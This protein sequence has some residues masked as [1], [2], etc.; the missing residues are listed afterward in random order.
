M[1]SAQPI[2]FRDYVHDAV[3]MTLRD[4]DLGNSKGGLNWICDR[5]RKGVRQNAAEL[6]PIDFLEEYLWCV[7]SIRK[8]YPTHVKYF[9]TQKELFLNCDACQ[10]TR[11][12]E[13]IRAA[14][15]RPEGRCDLSPRMFNAVLWTAGEIA[16]GWNGF[17]ENYLPLPADPE[18]ETQEAWQ[19]AY[20]AL[21]SL[22]MVGPALAWYLIRNLYGAP[23]FKPDVHIN[24][25]AWHFF[26]Q[27]A[28]PLRALTSAIKEVWPQVCTDKRLLPLHLGIA[29]HVLW[30]YRRETGQPADEQGE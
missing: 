25:I 19:E 29:D 2:P 20:R 10:I 1:T 4:A 28:D 23:F 27:H 17:R 22:P 18:A 21:D 3:G 24:V 26:G 6:S 11:N 14:W 8:K 5:A 12:A 16:V 15:D 30:W 13:V 7:G 9:P